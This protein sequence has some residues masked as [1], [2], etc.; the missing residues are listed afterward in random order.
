MRTNMRALERELKTSKKHTTHPAM[1]HA[2]S[3]LPL[4]RTIRMRGKR[5]LGRLFG[6]RLPPPHLGLVDRHIAPE[7]LRAEPVHSHC[8]A[9]RWAHELGEV[10]AAPERERS[11]ARQLS[12]SSRLVV[13]GRRC[14]VQRAPPKMVLHFEF[15]WAQL[16][17]HDRRV[18]PH[19]G[20]LALVIVRERFGFLDHR[21]VPQRAPQPLALLRGDL[22]RGGQPADCAIADREHRAVLDALDSE[23]FVHHQATARVLARVFA[24]GGGE[25]AHQ[26]P[27]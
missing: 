27:R 1:A 19:V 13:R 17:L 26:R 5:H 12:R 25:V 16:G 24:E 11:A 3:G 20:H 6:R 14:S 23:A 21:A 7:H 4:R 22:R 18:L 10:C 15:G 9:V 2:P 8:H